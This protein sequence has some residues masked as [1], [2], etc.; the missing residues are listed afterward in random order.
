MPQIHADRAPASERHPGSR[1][2]PRPLHVLKFG[3]SIFS[4]PQGYRYAAHEVRCHVEQGA[5]VVAVVSAM[6]DTTNTLLSF[7]NQ[8]TEDPPPELLSELLA[9]GEEISL[10]LLTM[11]LETV[12]VDA[13]GLRGRRFRPRTTGP[14][15]E[16]MPL[17]LDA[18]ALKRELEGGQ[19]VVYPGF[20]GVDGSGAPSLLGRGGSDLTALFLGH[21]LGA[22]HV[23]LLKDVEG[24]YPTPDFGLQHAKPL[25]HASWGQ[26]R[27]VGGGVVQHRALDFAAA[28]GVR[29][30]VCAPGGK[31]TLVCEVPFPG[32]AA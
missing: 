19:A 11:A 32:V 8:I 3:S 16:A 1:P 27:E 26:V 31:G 28:N 24:V 12:G 22:D 18:G 2:P 30:H 20:V 17:N 23:A 6:R 4:D 25:A 10:S 29:F 21:V 7:A 13:R 15:L 5:Q 9:S 14:L